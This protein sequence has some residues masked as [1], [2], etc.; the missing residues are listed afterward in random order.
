MRSLVQWEDPGLPEKDGVKSTVYELDFS[1]DGNLLVVACKNLVLV[2]DIK[3]GDL[4]HRLKGVSCSPA[5]SPFKPR[6]RR[7]LLFEAFLLHD[8]LPA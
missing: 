5:R 2:Y 7:R 8:C 1:R 3:E 4:M 6:R